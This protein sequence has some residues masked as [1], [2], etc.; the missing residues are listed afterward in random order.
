[1]NS[2]ETLSRVDA[3]RRLLRLVSASWLVLYGSFL[4]FN[5]GFWGGGVRE[6]SEMLARQPVSLIPFVYL[7]FCVCTS[8]ALRR[9]A[10][11]LVAGVVF[12]ALLAV[13]LVVHA[14]AVILGPVFVVAGVYIA[15]L[16]SRLYSRLE[17]RNEA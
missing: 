14:S 8:Y 6:F 10:A 13:F 17:R 7:G 12:H 16:W 4:L 15:F 1:M 2:S 3:A 9:S 5:V 11:L